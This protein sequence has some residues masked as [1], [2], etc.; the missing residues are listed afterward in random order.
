MNIAKPLV[1]LFLFF[2]CTLACRA[3]S[4]FRTIIHAH[5]DVSSGEDSF[6]ELVDVAR[7]YGVEAVFLTDN[8]WLGFQYG[9]PRLEQ[10]AWVAKN[11]PSVVQYG[12]RRY[13]RDIEK[14]NK[15]QDDV[16]LIPGI[17]VIPRCYWDGSLL[18]GDL[19]HWNMQRNLMILGV[20]DPAFIDNL[21]ISSGFVKHRDAASIFF[22]RALV[23]WMIVA[24]SL[25]SW[26][27]KARAYWSR[28]S[29]RTLRGGFILV[30]VL[31]SALVL[32][33]FNLF[34][35]GRLRDIYGRKLGVDAEQRVLDAASDKKYF[36]YW[37][38]PEANDDNKF[39]PIAIRTDP[40]PELLHRTRN[41]TAFG[42]LYEQGNTLYL[43]G[44]EWDQILMDYI[45]DVRGFP[46]WAIG[47]MLYRYEGH[48]GKKMYNV[49]TMIW[50]RKKTQ[51]ALIGAL[52][53]GRFYSRRRAPDGNVLTLDT[54]SVNG[55][56]A[57]R[58]AWVK[59]NRGVA[60]I[61]VAV[62]SE[63]PLT[64]PV[65]LTVVKN[66]EIF[67]E[68]EVH[69]PATVKLKDRVGSNE[70]MSYY[71]VYVRGA[72]PMQLVSNPIFVE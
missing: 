59:N 24:L 1:V 49:E 33:L 23:I 12:A 44:E 51:D 8:H 21:P 7:G 62:D 50:A 26:V 18:K 3:Q 42:A 47:E 39:G 45:H 55:R 66:G 35:G 27:P 2:A 17:E 9:L 69:L 63:L 32:L 60:Q 10:V 36:T 25:L 28:R 31:P 52:K 29:V 14:M 70:K 68:A 30:V 22:S 61:A 40:Y 71:R 16:L 56:P 34:Q 4:A 72:Y 65:T 11:L 15:K 5:T 53:Q 38:H 58:G 64:K 67:H 46:V 37:A 54:F 13:L 57:A 6:D 48:A 41:Y 19:T 20:D 43:A